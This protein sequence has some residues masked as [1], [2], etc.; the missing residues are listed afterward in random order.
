MVDATSPIRNSTSSNDSSNDSTSNLNSN[1][2]SVNDNT[3]K[4][5]IQ[6]LGLGQ[7]YS[8]INPQFLKISRYQ[9]TL[10][11]LLK[12]HGYDCLVYDPVFEQGDRV[13]IEWFGM[14]VARGAGGETSRIWFMPHCDYELYL[15]IVNK[16]N[17]DKKQQLIM[18]NSFEW[19]GIIGK[20]IRAK[21]E[22]SFPRFEID[23]QVFN[24]TCFHLV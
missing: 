18:G 9:F 1:D 22:V 7:I 13:L 5:T 2:T 17:Q 23:E 14:R 3:K 4:P 6:C 19:Y 12:D 21:R 24:N 10:L 11:I 16:E 20:E 8:N 15:D